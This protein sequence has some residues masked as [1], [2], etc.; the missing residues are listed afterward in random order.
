MYKTLFF[1]L[2]IVSLIVSFVVTGMGGWI[3]ITGQPILVTK[4]HAWNDGLF[5]ILLAIFFILVAKL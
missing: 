4:Q 5:M 3:D 1:T 2:A